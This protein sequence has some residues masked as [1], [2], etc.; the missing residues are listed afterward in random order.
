MCLAFAKTFKMVTNCISCRI[1]KDWAGWGLR[2]KIQVPRKLISEIWLE[3]CLIPANTIGWEYH[4][5]E[6]HFT[7]WNLVKIIFLTRK[8]RNKELD[9]LFGALSSGHWAVGSLLPCFLPEKSSRHGLSLRSCNLN[10]E[11]SCF[12][13]LFFSFLVAGKTI[14]MLVIGEERA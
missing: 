4:M 5:W 8:H 12:T 1:I 14:W 3:S 7:D 2:R 10:L 9:F 6:L 13:A 11:N